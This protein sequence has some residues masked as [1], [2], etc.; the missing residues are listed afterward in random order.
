MTLKRAVVLLPLATL[1]AGLLSGCGGPQ[2][3]TA[4]C[5][6][7]VD[8]TGSSDAKIG[9]NAQQEIADHLPAFL[10]KTKCGTVYYAPISGDSL[11]SRCSEDPID[12]DPNVT[13][14][15][16]RSEMWTAYRGLAVKRADALQSCVRSDPTSAGGS[17]VLGGL[18]VIARDR[19]AGGASFPVLVVSD[20]LE[21]DRTVNLYS[22]NL[23]A[24]TARS[25]LI[26]RLG[27]EGRIPDLSDIELSAAGY[28][29]LQSRN[30]AQFSGFDLFW[31]QLLRER[32]KVTAPLTIM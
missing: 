6:V 5:G 32:A 20:F 13:G 29:M 22:A 8:G 10:V 2:R 26:A 11:A 16:D 12:I 14:D 24:Q 4:M 15:V 25:R 21:N 18:A 30:P 19:P 31:R 1:A 7:V 17:D 9:F 27:D 23:A 3:L 28:G